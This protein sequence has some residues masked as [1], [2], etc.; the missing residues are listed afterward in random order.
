MNAQEKLEE[1]EKESEVMLISKDSERAGTEDAWVAL[2][3]V[4]STPPRMIV[5]HAPSFSAV[6]NQLYDKWLEYK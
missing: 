3:G 5:T 1:I 6:V 4:M 2:V